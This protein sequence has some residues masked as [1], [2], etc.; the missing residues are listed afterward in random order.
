MTVLKN[1]RCLLEYRLTRRSDDDRHRY[2]LEC[3]HWS[4]DIS[5]LRG[6][7]L[8]VVTARPYAPLYRTA[9]EADAAQ[10][11]EE[12]NRLRARAVKGGFPRLIVCCLFA[13]RRADDADPVGPDNDAQIREAAAESG[14][15]IAAW[16]AGL[17]D[18]SRR[19]DE[20]TALLSGRNIHALGDGAAAHQWP[21]RADQVS[22][23]V[24]PVL[25]REAM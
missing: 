4:K 7:A 9:I 16:G 10:D 13:A 21:P 22:P 8:M 15:I 24:P 5:T 6:D 14:M 3:R 20:V 12:L 11:C 23:N 17:G 18:H 2:W 19:A 25:W 1:E